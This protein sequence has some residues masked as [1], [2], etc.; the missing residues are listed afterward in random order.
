[1]SGISSVMLVSSRGISLWWYEYLSQRSSSHVP[2]TCV[3]ADRTA[4]VGSNSRWARCDTTSSTDLPLPYCTTSPA[5]QTDRRTN[6]HPRRHPSF[7][8]TLYCY[9]IIQWKL[10]FEK[11]M[12]GT[13]H[14]SQK[15]TNGFAS[16]YCYAMLSLVSTGMGDHLWTGGTIAPR[17]VSLT[18]QL[19]QLV[20]TMLG[21]LKLWIVLHIEN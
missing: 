3:T 10:K 19:G 17:C 11:K 20:T 6:T 8:L 5:W 7:T 21:Q 4:A 2:T 14:L 15:D 18:S 12:F 1:M 9:S 13:E 16:V